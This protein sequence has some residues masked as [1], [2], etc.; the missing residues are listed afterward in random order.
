VKHVRGALALICILLLTACAVRAVLLL[1]N[2]GPSVVVRV[3][4]E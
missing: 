4:K 2:I 1:F 3:E